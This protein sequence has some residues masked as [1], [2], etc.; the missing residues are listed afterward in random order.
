MKIVIGNKNYSSWS[1]RP[2]LALKHLGV[3]F[4]E[5]LI[6]LSQPD[7]PQRNRQFSPAGKVPILI[8]GGITVWESLAI[9]EYLAEK[10]P[11]ADLWPR[12]TAA[13][14]NA[15]AVSCEMLSGFRALRGA[16]PM[17]LRRPPRKL[18]IDDAV[19]ADVA[20]MTQIWRDARAE[21]GHGGPFLYGAFT[22]ADAMF[23][24]AATR[25]RTYDIDMDPVS[26]AYVD[27]IH[28]FEPFKAWHAEA[29]K[30]TWIVPHDEVDDTITPG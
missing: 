24:A 16:C 21:H 4:E 15:R 3:E 6:P 22:I 26:R 29:L 23:S 25:F 30:E 2:W 17:N 28:E 14:A 11:D 8:D 1:L 27:T 9:L 19:K 7:T 5:E 12:G 10:Y 20:R 13:R 18:A